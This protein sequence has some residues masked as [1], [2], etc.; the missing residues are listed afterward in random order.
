MMRTLAAGS[1]ESSGAGGIWFTGGDD[2][3]TRFGVTPASRSASIVTSDGVRLV[4]GDCAAARARMPCAGEAAGG[5][6]DMRS[7]AGDSESC[8]V[9]ESA[10]AEGWEVVVA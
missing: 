7:G 9:G 2:G 5:N 4:G 1:G 3:A 10:E 8:L 6:G